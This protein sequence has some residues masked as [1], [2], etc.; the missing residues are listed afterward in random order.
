MIM[1]SM[2]PILAR[3]LPQP[4]VQVLASQLSPWLPLRS[5]C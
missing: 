5:V 2:K 1:T 3:R 4:G